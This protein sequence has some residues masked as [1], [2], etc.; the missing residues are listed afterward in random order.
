MRKG[1]KKFFAMALAVT[2]ALGTLT[3]C[4]SSGESKD[5]NH[6]LVAIMK[7]WHLE[8]RSQMRSGDATLGLAPLPERT[9]LS[10]GFFC[11]F[12]TFH[13]VVCCRSDGIF[14]A[15]NIDVEYQSFTGG[16][17][18]MMEANADWD[19]CGCWCTWYVKWYEEL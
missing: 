5:T 10:I 2:V 9:T 12:S 3:G 18:M 1:T 19:V 7:L 17:C 11:R 6:L 14:D 8:Q 13:A 4:G 15:L 16:L